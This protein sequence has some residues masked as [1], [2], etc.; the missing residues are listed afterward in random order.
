VAATTPA[1]ERA[2]RTLPRTT[3]GSRLHLALPLAVIGGGL[4]LRLVLALVVFPGQGLSSDM[5]L[6]SSWAATLARIGPSGFYAAE[7]TANYPPAYMWVL[8]LVGVLGGGVELLKLPAILAD[9]GIAALLYVAGRRWLGERAGLIAAALYL[10]VPVSWYDSALW[11]Q[12]DA[13]GALVM[14]AAVVLLAE[15]WSE[16]AAALGA[17]AA[18]VKPQDAIVLVVILPVLVR[19]HLLRVGSG[20]APSLPRSLRGLET[21]VRALLADQGPVRL[22]TSAIA[23]A[24]VTVA[25]LL[26]FDIALYAPANLA[27]VPVLGQL[28]GLVGLMVS[29]TGQ[30]GVLTANAFNPW[31]IVGP[32]P[33]AAVIGAGGGSWTADSL[34]VVAGIS[35][36]TVGAVLLIGTALL[37]G[38]GLLV[39]D[40]RMT[41]VLALAVMTFA[42][43]ALPTRVHERYLVPFFAPGALLAAAWLPAI[44]W[45]VVVAVLDTANL[46]TILADPNAAGKSAGAVGGAGRL[47]GAFGGGAGPGGGG[48][49]GGVGPGTFGGSGPGGFGGSGIASIRLPFPDLAR[50]EVAVALIAAGQTAGFVLLLAAWVVTVIRP[51]ALPLGWRPRG[52]PRVAAPAPA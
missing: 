45:Y 14:L 50:S 4:A 51:S 34:P 26:P 47:G 41:L 23:A 38:G 28:A 19:R 16:P 40:G 48:F 44:A 9:A 13:V 12:V 32:S 31:A 35:A 6:F 37:V 30:F 20:P 2:A 52:G 7:A 10:L 46:H 21:T 22:A 39:R 29:D 8:W 36:A 49:G 24:V 17:L 25:V 11:G 15:G 43:Y 3:V 33:L 27:D 42:F 5:G 18:L 1:V